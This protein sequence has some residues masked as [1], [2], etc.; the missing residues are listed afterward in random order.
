MDTNEAQA[1]I[2]E[3]RPEPPL[4]TRSVVDDRCHTATWWLAGGE[5]VIP[6]PVGDGGSIE[7]MEHDLTDVEWEIHG[8]AI[9]N[10]MVGDPN[11]VVTCVKD[12]R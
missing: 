7:D 8:T 4:T 1:L 10:G 12:L 11:F 2:D 5:F 6:P 9:A 3:R